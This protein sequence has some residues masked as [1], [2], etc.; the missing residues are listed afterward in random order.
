MSVGLSAC[1]SAWFGAMFVPHSSLQ[2][3]VKWQVVR[4]TIRCGRG[5]SVYLNCRVSGQGMLDCAWAHGSLYI[6]V[7][8]WT[9]GFSSSAAITTGTA[10]S[11]QYL[12]THKSI[13]P[14]L[15]DTSM[16]SH[17]F[18]ICNNAMPLNLK[19]RP[20]TETIYLQ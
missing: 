18:I 7:R 8:V 10:G 15:V 4:P 6:Y 19:T 5:V 9:R 17:W 13:T 20:P 12:Q 11:L 3:D 16:V 2:S 14:Q 1:P